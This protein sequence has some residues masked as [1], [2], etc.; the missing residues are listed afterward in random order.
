MTREEFVDSWMGL[1]GFTDYSLDGE[2]VT[3]KLDD[4]GTWTKHAL[5]CHCGEE[6]CN[7]W[8]MIPDGNQNFHKYQNGLTDMTYQEACAADAVIHKA[9]RAQGE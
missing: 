8:A 7:G 5:E 2:V 1:S 4:G 3:L 9:R 6:G